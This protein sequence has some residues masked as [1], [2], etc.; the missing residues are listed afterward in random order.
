MKGV[1]TVAVHTVLI[2]Y[3]FSLLC[4][5]EANISNSLIIISFQLLQPASLLVDNLVLMNSLKVGLTSVIKIRIL[6][7]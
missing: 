2:V 3:L 5:L 4:L 6:S 7:D 1:D